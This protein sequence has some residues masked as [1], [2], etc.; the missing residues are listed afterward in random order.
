MPHQVYPADEICIVLNPLQASLRDTLH[1]L[2]TLLK[3]Q[4]KDI[5]IGKAQVRCV[6]YLFGYF[7][8]TSQS[9]Y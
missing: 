7:M 1:S 3:G 9:C 8:P 6:C 5:I 2:E 4:K